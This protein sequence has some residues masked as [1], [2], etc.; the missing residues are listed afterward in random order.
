MDCKFD[1]EMGPRGPTRVAMLSKSLVL[2]NFFV[3]LLVWF[4]M[5]DVV[6]HDF[7]KT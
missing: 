4:V 7:Q 6:F 5:G 3:E 2:I 1:C